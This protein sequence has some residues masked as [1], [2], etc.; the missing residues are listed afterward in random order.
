MKLAYLETDASV[1]TRRELVGL[2][3]RLFAAGAGVLIRDIQH[4]PLAAKSV[5]LGHL[6]SPLH[7]ETLA[8][9]LGFEAAADLGIEGVWAIT[10]NERLAESCNGGSEN[11]AFG[12]DLIEQRLREARARFVFARVR[13]SRGSHRKRRFGGPSADALARAAIGLGGRR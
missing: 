6:P 8:L 9:A 1:D 12:L 13:W 10:D 3:G 7:A 5:A 4:R 2:D 11:H